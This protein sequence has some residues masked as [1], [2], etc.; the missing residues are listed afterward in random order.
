MS[1]MDGIEYVIGIDQSYARTAYSICHKGNIIACGSFAP[2]ASNRPTDKRKFIRQG[3]Y[4]ATIKKARI[5]GFTPANTIVLFER[6][7]MFSRG[8][9]SMNYIVK[10]GALIAIMADMFIEAGYQCYTVDTRAWKAGVIGT[11]K[12]K[13]NKYGINPA[14]WPTIL[15]VRDNR[16]VP[17]RKFLVPEKRH[18][19][20]TIQIRGKY[21]SINDDVCDAICISKYPFS[22]T[23]TE[24]D[25]LIKPAD[26]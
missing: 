23:K 10:T 17:S 4:Q 14:K 24:I 22:K 25:E 1:Y 26:F 18:K 6:I 7:R 5:A 20:G 15:Y 21:Y 8:F 11:S 12:P 16:I 19:K 3:I 2:E 13:N 9:L